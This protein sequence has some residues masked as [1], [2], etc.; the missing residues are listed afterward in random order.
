MDKKGVLSTLRFIIFTTL[1]LALICCSVIIT[2]LN[3]YKPAVKTYVNGK[4][5]GYFTSEQNFDEVYNSLVTEKQ[6]IDSNVKV[7]LESEPTFETSYIKNQLLLE[8]NLYTNLRSELKTEYIIYNVAVD[9]ETKMTFSSKDE[10]NIYAEKLKSEVSKL[11]VEVKEEKKSELENITTIERADA[12]LKDIV[13]RNKP[14][15][16]P[17]YTYRYN[18]NVTAPT[19][20]PNS[21]AAT[22]KG[23]WPT[24]ERRINCHYM[25]YAGHTGIDIGGAVGTAIYAYRSG[26]VTFSGWGSGYG[27][28]IKI[29]HGDGMVTYYAHCSEL[30]VSAGEKVKEGQIICK[31]GMTGYTT[32]PHLHFE[33]RLNG[34]PVNPYPYIKGK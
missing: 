28:Y 26:T 19:I 12:I 25:G 20:G 21:V 8:Q 6:N 17:K 10:A 18:A 1:I 31:I 2:V 16:T 13:D 9:G 33:I 22:G 7:Y 29:N 15:E 30:L 34:V 24:V 32:G 5:I 23:V 4:F 27:K 11:K 3:T 14:V